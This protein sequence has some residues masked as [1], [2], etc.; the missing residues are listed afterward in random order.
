MRG[1]F[2]LRRKSRE[3]LRVKFE[4]QRVPE[5]S[6]ATWTRYEIWQAAGPFV[7]RSEG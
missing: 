6:L 4:S 5:R 2:A 3:V 1:I 7:A